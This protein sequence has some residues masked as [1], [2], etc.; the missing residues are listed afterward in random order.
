YLLFNEGYH[1]AH[2]H[3][4]VRVELCAE[5]IRLVSILASEPRT[6]TPETH[7]LLALMCLT[8]ARLP[9]RRD[10]AGSLAPL[11]AQ[12]RTR[13]DA[14][15]IQRG[16]AALEASATGDALSAW[17]IEAA[18]AYEHAVA[19]SHEATDFERIVALYDVLG[20]LRP[21]PVVA[22][23]RAIAIG[24]VEGPERAL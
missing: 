9:A 14:A 4:T 16:T 7:A 11:A 20:R 23:S 5:A 8:A 15:L 22:L 21:S 19:P 10:E 2:P 12:D 6:A 3:E 17:H 18:I 24:E 13:F 1:G